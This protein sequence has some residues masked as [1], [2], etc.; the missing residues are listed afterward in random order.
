MFHHENHSRSFIYICCTTF[1]GKIQAL[2]TFWASLSLF[3]SFL[4]TSFLFVYWR[5]ERR[6]PHT[7]KYVHIHSIKSIPF[8]SLFFSFFLYGELCLCA[9]LLTVWWIIQKLL[10]L[11][12]LLFISV[13]YLSCN[14]TSKY[15][16]EILNPL[17]DLRRCTNTFHIH[18]IPIITAISPLWLALMMTTPIICTVTVT[19]LIMSIVTCAR[20]ILAALMTHATNDTIPEEVDRP[21]TQAIR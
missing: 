18:S 7:Y 1:N 19:K 2:L 20:S 8:S 15:S 6:I 13:L 3:L 21:G 16:F 9:Q 12:L 4:F 10:L 11:L 5:K 14:K 17:P